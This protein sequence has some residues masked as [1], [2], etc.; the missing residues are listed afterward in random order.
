MGKRVWGSKDGS[1]TVKDCFGSQDYLSQGPE[2][3]LSAY[4][5]SKGGVEAFAPQKPKLTKNDWQNKIGLWNYNNELT[6][7]KKMSYGEKLQRVRTDVTLQELNQA[8]KG[9]AQAMADLFTLQASL[10]GSGYHKKIGSK[11]IKTKLW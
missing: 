8:I 5:K 11:K 6:A 9:D 4:I 3:R 7:W 10:G 1:K 2:Q